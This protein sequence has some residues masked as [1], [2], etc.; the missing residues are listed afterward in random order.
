MVGL[1]VGPFLA[2]FLIMIVECCSGVTPGKLMLRM[3]V[4]EADGSDANLGSI[5]SRGLL[6]YQ[7][8]WVP[9][10][11]ALVGLDFLVTISAL[12][13]IVMFFGIF[14]IFGERRQTL[15]DKMAQTTVAMN[16]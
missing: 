10:V 9:T 15:W 8:S 14:L 13:S 7:Y 2:S 5:V 11:G 16:N 6:K 12:F 4:S 1:F 3:K